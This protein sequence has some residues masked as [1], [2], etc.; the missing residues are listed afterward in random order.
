MTPTSSATTQQDYPPAVECYLGNELSRA[1]FLKKGQEYLAAVQEWLKANNAR[2]EGRLTIARYT[3]AYDSAIQAAYDYVTSHWEADHG[4]APPA[5]ALAALG[6]Y[7]RR[8]LFLQS[9]I[10]LLVIMDNNGKTD[11]E[12]VKSLLHLLIDWRLN[13][14]YATRTVS[15]CEGRVGIDLDSTTAMTEA[16]LLIGSKALFTRCAEAVK[17]AVTGKARKWYLRSMLEEWRKRR[18]KFESTVFLLEPNLKE[19]PGGLRDVHTVQWFLFALVGSADMR[20]LKEHARFDDE[21]MREYRE[22]IHFVQTVRNE[23]HIASAGKN[24]HLVFA[25]QPAIA[26]ALGYQQDAHRSPEEVFM[27]DYYRHARVIARASDR[28]IRVMSVDNQSIFAGLVGSLRRRRIDKHLMVQDDVLFIDPAFPNYLE[29]DTAR[30]MPLFERAARW[31]LC[32]S[33]QTIDRL[34]RISRNLGPAFRLAPANHASFLRILRAT[35]HVAQ[36]IHD[37]HACGILDKIIPEFERLTCMVR[38]DHYH[39]YTVDEHTIKALEMAEKLRR[40]DPRARTFVG[41]IAA[42]I[43]RWDLL[44][45]A[46]LLHDIGKGYGRGHALRGGQIAQRVGDRLEL[47]EEDV[48]TVRF[49]VLSH[50]KLSHAAQRRDLADPSVAHQLAEEIGTLNRL[51]LLYVHSVCDLMAVSPEAWNDWKAQLLADCYMRT[52]EVLGEKP[53]SPEMPEPDL[54]KL[55]RL[56]TAAILKDEDQAALAA[57]RKPERRAKRELETLNDEVETFLRHATDRYV[58]AATPEAMAQHAVMLRTLSDTQPL[59]WMVLPHA[60]S[61]LSEIAVVAYDVPGLFQS[62]CGALAAKSINIWSAQIYST[63]DGFAINQFQVTDLDNKPLPPGLRLER[64][65]HDLNLVL[66]GEMTI[67]K[68]IEKHRGRTRKRTRPRSPHPSRVIFDNTS[69]QEYTILEIRTTDRPGL[70]YRITHALS[71][72]QL[73]I[74]RAIITT[75]AYGVVD[76]FYVT[77]LEYNKAIDA[78]L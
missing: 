63:T 41:R 6:G 70:L 15:D 28:A 26:Q 37:M 65:H 21:E 58:Q 22:A 72:C 49:L 42:Q 33:E 73:D 51:K 59:N 3:K 18:E 43:K 52:A 11:E 27:A 56:V 74:K 68:L 1:K 24:D 61:G 35:S 5:I 45:L 44:L 32:L 40:E 36:T 19:C 77:D 9:D 4:T 7:G 71:E 55:R 10:D 29:E 2:L 64:V 66:R 20:H 17:S 34:Q 12:Y 13:L 78:E 62:I 60:G 57:G 31:G 8:E 30:V 46:L 23:L 25:F 48:E 39:H 50:L 75:E 16:R 47:P 67:E 76:V 53:N 38:I 69:S 14:G 54:E